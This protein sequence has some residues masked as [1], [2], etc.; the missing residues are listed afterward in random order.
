MNF[1]AKRQ[2]ILITYKKN[3][4]LRH[5]LSRNAFRS[6]AP[7]AYHF[8]KLS[9]HNHYNHGDMLVLSCSSNYVS[10]VSRCK[11]QSN[12]TLGYDGKVPTSL[13]ESPE[14]WLCRL[15]SGP[16]CMLISASLY[17]FISI[18]K[19]HTYCIRSCLFL[20]L[21]II[22]LTLQYWF[23]KKKYTKVECLLK[24]FK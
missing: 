21:K 19:T 22:C 17:S 10:C 6:A 14:Y 5:T 3:L 23:Y 8:S 1:L 24:I 11:M 15:T 7:M 20:L 18:S 4:A 16:K 2:I 9:P 12:V 13:C